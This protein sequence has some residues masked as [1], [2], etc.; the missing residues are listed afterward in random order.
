MT[1]IVTCFKLPISLKFNLLLYWH[2]FYDI[3][4]IW[5]HIVYPRSDSTELAV[6]FQMMIGALN[7]HTH[8]GAKQLRPDIVQINQAY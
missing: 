4:I 7:S 8:C 6:E 5:P 2:G 1:C 3:L